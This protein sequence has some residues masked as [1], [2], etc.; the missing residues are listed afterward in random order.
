MTFWKALQLSKITMKI[1][2]I[3][4]IDLDAAGGGMNTVIPELMKSQIEYDPSAEVTLLNL[5][6][7]RSSSYEIPAVGLNKASVKELLSSD[8]VVFHSVYRMKFIPLYLLLRLK[9]VPYL[10]VSHGGLAKPAVA[11]GKLKKKLFKIL[12]MD[13]FVKNS[14]SLCFTSDAEQSNSA[15]TKQRYITVPNPISITDYE[16]S[17]VA[18]P[19]DKLSMIFLSKIDV[20]YKGLDILFNALE[21]IKDKIQDKVSISFYGYG[22]SKDVDL[23]NIPETEKDINYLLKRISD[24]GL[25]D[26]SYKGPIFGNEKMEA[27]KNSDIYILTSRSEAMPLSI[28][29]SLS[30]GTPCM[31]SYGTNMGEMVVEAGAGWAMDLNQD[32]IAQTLLKAIEEYSQNPSQYRASARSLYEKNSS[33]NIGEVSIKQYKEI[34]SN[35]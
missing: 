1:F 33:V 3:A 17:T 6:P 5:Q 12:F 22:N 20:Y 32:D 35:L 18:E 15:Y 27:L 28:T 34:I 10:I 2:H 8:V 13:R 23:N 25:K 14:A 7:L 29:E 9:R 21:S 30:V 31:V 24:L 19:K 26:I 4:S 16:P 11:K